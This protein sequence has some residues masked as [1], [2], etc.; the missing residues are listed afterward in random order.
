MEKKNYSEAF[1][2]MIDCQSFIRASREMY[3]CVTNTGKKCLMQ[4]IQTNTHRKVNKDRYIKLVK[5]LC[6]NISPED[7][8][9]VY[10]HEVNF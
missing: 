7:I 6:V 3:L 8:Y 2:R 1:Q 5:E 9:W 4:E 10:T